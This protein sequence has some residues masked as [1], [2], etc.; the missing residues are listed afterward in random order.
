MGG[1][2]ALFILITL[3]CHLIISILIGKWSSKGVV[4]F[5]ITFIASWFLTPL[6]GLLFA[7]ISVSIQKNT[8]NTKTVADEIEKLKSLRDRDL[9]TEDEFNIAKQKLLNTL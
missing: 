4:P 6:A 1:F 3:P 8:T 9:L 2:E 5:W 7:L